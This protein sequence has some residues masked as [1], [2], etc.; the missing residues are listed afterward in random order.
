MTLSAYEQ[1]REKTIA[2]NNEVLKS[3][4]LDK[5]L[6][7]KKP[8]VAKKKKRKPEDDPEYS[9]PEKRATRITGGKI[10]DDDYSDDDYASI[11]KPKKEKSAA[12]KTSPPPPGSCIVVEAAKTGRSKC[13]KCFEMLN[14][15]ELRVGME[16]WMVGRQVMVWQ[17]P[18]CFMSGLQVTAEP[19]G[20]G[21]CKQCKEP[22]EAGEQR[23]SA[24]AHNTTN[25]FKLDAAAKLLRPV[26]AAC[27]GAKVTEIEGFDELKPAERKAFKAAVLA[28]EAKVEPKKEFEEM[29]VEATPST[30]DVVAANDDGKQPPKGRVTK[31]SGKVCWRFAGVLC[32]GVLLPAQESVSTC[33]ARTH[34]GK[35][36]TLTKGGASWW[37]V[38]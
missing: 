10:P 15:G 26:F 4:G 9:P 20:R 11:P 32:Y 33:Y 14:E 35:T 28:K 30:A 31:A 23:L 21:K 36:K 24:S 22:F 16:S 13:R 17:H 19:T 38:E 5:P 12:V 18:Q 3:L 34:K 8:V 6:F 27:K 29:K 2:R 25:H 37:M 1:E 7:A